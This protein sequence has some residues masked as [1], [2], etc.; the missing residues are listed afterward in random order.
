MLED[1]IEEIK[2]LALYFDQINIV[3]QRHIH[4]L[5]PEKNAK[6]VKKN[7]KT[8]VESKVISTND[9]TEKQ[10]ILHLK[11]FEKN[12]VIKY[13]MDADSGGTGPQPGIQSISSDMQINDLV[14]FHS[15]LVGTK[16]NEKQF[17][18]EKGRIVLSY[19][20][21]LNKEAAHLTEKLFND[22]N[23]TNK[24]MSYYARVF[25]TFVNYYER[26]ENV[27]TSSK[28]VNDLFKEISK[29]DR[30]KAAQTAFK[31]EF[32]ITPSF[33]LEAIKLGVPD[34]GKFPPEEILK[35]KEKSKD[36]LLEFQ[37]KLETIT[38]DLL[39]QYD[40]NYINNNAQKIADLKIK[41]LIDNISNSLDN[42]KFK[43][44]QEL[45][46]EAR[47]PKS[48]SPLL[49]T[50]SDKI[51]NSM[52]LLISAGLV[53]LN[54]GLEHYSKIKEAKKDGVYYLYKMKKYFT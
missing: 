49:L 23:N 13:L 44:I 16:H 1:N 9:F 4:I 34:L 3:E 31:S 27:L 25:K 19:D 28:Y 21:E 14:L 24:L 51:S 8:Y 6:T 35:F 38:F 54:V 42:S 45:I 11:E 12:K 40:F 5:A 48:Y 10:F 2:S 30:F 33:A 32:N 29:T 20:L 52:I 41:P 26:G 37:T 15:E 7:G 39:N 36:E 47:D 17:T 46:K 18:D 50:F 22:T 53:G 43:V